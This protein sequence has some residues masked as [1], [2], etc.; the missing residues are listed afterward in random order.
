M[1]ACLECGKQLAPDDLQCSHCGWSWLPAHGMSA[2]KILTKKMAEQFLANDASVDLNGFTT[3]E[4]EAR[5]VFQD[6]GF[7]LSEYV[8]QV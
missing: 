3:M 8:G 5:Q 7:N 2:E 4:P 1:E 6:A